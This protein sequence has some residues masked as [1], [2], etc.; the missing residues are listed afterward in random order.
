MYMPKKLNVLLIKNIKF[1]LVHSRIGDRF[2]LKL[3]D[4]CNLTIYGSNTKELKNSLPTEDFYKLHLVEHR[5][6]YKVDEMLKLCGEPDV[7][8]LHQ[9]GA[10]KSLSPAGFADLKIP[11]ALMLFDTYIREG[12]TANR[13]KLPYIKDNNIDLI[14]RRGCKSFY[15]V[16]LWEKPSV[17][18]PFSVR[19]ENYFTDPDTQYLYGR[20][21]RITFVGGGYESK[22]KLYKALKLAVDTLKGEGLIDYQGIVGIHKYPNA[23]KSYVAGLSYSF[24]EF[25]GHPAKLFELMGSGTA[26]LTT[27]FTN[28]KSLFGEEDC[29]WEFRSNCNNLVDVAKE[30]TSKDYRPELYKRTRNA[31]RAINSKHLDKHRI[32]ELYNILKALAEGDEIPQTWE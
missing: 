31:L 23:I 19:E 5:N 4:L 30:L 6:E 26:V 25:Q 27:T 18:L 29:Y 12:Q 20:H 17:W 1:N 11:K 21:N 22:N 9:A 28:A 8:L 13:A 14:I 2:L 10:A 3:N 7:I 24:E 16:S 15:D 32:V